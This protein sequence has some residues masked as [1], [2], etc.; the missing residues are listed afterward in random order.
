MKIT[1]D[2]I[3][4]MAFALNRL[5]DGLERTREFA[6]SVG[7]GEFETSYEPLSEE[8]ELGHTLLKMRDDLA[9]TERELERKVDMRTDEV[10]RQKEEIEVQ[11]NRVTEL[12]K[13]LMSS[14]NYAKRLQNTILPSHLN[15]V[16]GLSMVICN[17]KN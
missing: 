10:V 16:V 17:K 11:R 5:V 15:E 9:I 8:D 1:N 6:N 14:I 4:D 2:E 3:G 7:Q 12:Y 13:D